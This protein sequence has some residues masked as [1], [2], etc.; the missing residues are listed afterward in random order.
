MP[1]VTPFVALKLMLF[2]TGPKSGRP[3]AVI[4]ARC[5][6]SLN[7]P[8]LS[9]CTGR[10]NTKSP[11]MFVSVTFSSFSKSN[12]IP[13]HCPCCLYLASVAAFAG[14]HQS[15]LSVYHLMVCSRPFWKSVCVGFQPS[16]VR[17]FVL[18]IA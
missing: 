11:G 13:D 18:S 10:S 14:S 6:F 2:C 3:N 12:T 5:Q 8:R 17:S 7:Q 1:R 9:P 16:S 4:F 15:R